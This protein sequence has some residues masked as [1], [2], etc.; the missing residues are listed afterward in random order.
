MTVFV[1][2][3]DQIVRRLGWTDDG[4]ADDGWTGGW[5]GGWTDRQDCRFVHQVLPIH[6]L[7]IFSPCIS[8][9]FSLVVFLS[10]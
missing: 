10:C 7:N 2:I 1:V 9:V 8:S 3:I 4:L 6:P 5:P